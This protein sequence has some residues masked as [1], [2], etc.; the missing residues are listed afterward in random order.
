M[1]ACVRRTAS[2]SSAS[3][4]RLRFRSRASCRRPWYRPQSTRRRPCG[5]SRRCIEPVTS[6]AAP[7]KRIA[8]VIAAGAD[9]AARGSA[10]DEPAEAL[11]EGGALAQL[12]LRERVEQG[13]LARGVGPQAVEEGP[14]ERLGDTLEID[15]D[16]EL[17]EIPPQL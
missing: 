1:C 9:V 4:G 13:L 16:A 3:R 10:T 5:V 2:A 12:A 7:R 17:A 6:R 8:V 15:R 11:D 14:G